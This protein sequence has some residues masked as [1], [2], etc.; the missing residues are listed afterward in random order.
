M[1]NPISKHTVTVSTDSN[2]EGLQPKQ[3]NWNYPL[4]SKVTALTTALPQ[5]LSS[6]FR[7]ACL[8]LLPQA[9]A[10]CSSSPSPRSIFVVNNATAF[11]VTYDSKEVSAN[12][13]KQ[14]SLSCN[15]TWLN[16]SIQG[17]FN[18]VK[19]CVCSY[20]G[21][22][23]DTFSTIDLYSQNTTTNDNQCM[24][25]KL[26]QQICPI[27][28]DSSLTGPIMFYSLMGIFALGLLYLCG[29]KLQQECCPSYTRFDGTRS[30]SIDSRGGLKAASVV[31][32]SQDHQDE[33]R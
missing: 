30:Q 10:T 14:A 15:F 21:D 26:P 4:S 18:T 32:L 12:Q 24:I 5:L 28:D 2:S 31:L 23:G 29:K 9:A 33:G 27:I 16:G 22:F 7:L 3:P 25:T 19:N 8:L 11:K 17:A 20:S 6:S 13:I 1:V